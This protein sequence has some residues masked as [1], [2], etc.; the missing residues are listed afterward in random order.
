[1]RFSNRL[2]IHITKLYNRSSKMDLDTTALKV[3]RDA[4]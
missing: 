1:M 4:T 2:Q 3:L